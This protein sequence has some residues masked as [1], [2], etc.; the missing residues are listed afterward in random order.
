MLNVT[1]L[2]EL[3]GAVWTQSCVS[4]MLFLHAFHKGRTHKSSE[5]MQQKN[6]DCIS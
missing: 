4:S 5:L 2:G 3:G 6:C 1:V